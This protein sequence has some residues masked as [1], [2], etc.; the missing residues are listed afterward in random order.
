VAYRP[1]DE[2]RKARRGTSRGKHGYYVCAWEVSDA[3]HGEWLYDLTW[4]QYSRGNTLRRVPLVLECEWHLGGVE[5]D[6]QKLVLA[7]AEHRVMLY[8]RYAHETLG[9]GATWLLSH[10]KRLASGRKPD[11]YL[12]RAWNRELWR[13]D[14]QAHRVRGSA[15]P[16]QRGGKR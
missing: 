14:W 2:G 15:E 7:R 1:V 9:D 12:F 4:L 5:E 3:D 13:F 16:V 10:A 11:H 6:F 8:A